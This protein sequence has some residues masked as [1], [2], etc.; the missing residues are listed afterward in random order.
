MVQK[1]EKQ[2]FLDLICQVRDRYGKAKTPKSL[3]DLLNEQNILFREIE[4]QDSSLP[5][6]DE[7]A[8]WRKKAPFLSTEVCE[9]EYYNYPIAKING[10]A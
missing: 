9:M 3:F 1:G 10:I 2:I 6:T 5:D 7:I 8:V 4:F